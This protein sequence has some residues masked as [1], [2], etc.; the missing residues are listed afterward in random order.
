[1]QGE[2]ETMGLKHD[3]AEEIRCA[4]FGQQGIGM[5]KAGLGNVLSNQEFLNFQ[6]QF[7]T[8][9]GTIIS[10]SNFQDPAAAI[11]TI[12][13]KI[14]QRYPECTPRPSSPQEEQAKPAGVQVRG[15]SAQGAPRRG[16]AVRVRGGLPGLRVPLSQDGAVQ[17]AAGA[18][19]DGELLLLWRTRKG[20]ALALHQELAQS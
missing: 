14:A 2:M 17:R 13:A 4:A 12:K 19:G 6:R 20:H 8:P 9:H 18:A 16:G 1:M 5:L 3:M 15:R 7:L 11:A 10:L